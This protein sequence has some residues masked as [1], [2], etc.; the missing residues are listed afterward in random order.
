MNKFLVTE[1]VESIP[2]FLEY[3]EKNKDLVSDIANN[4]GH[5]ILKVFILNEDENKIGCIVEGDIKKAAAGMTNPEINSFMKEAGVK[6]DTIRT[7][8]YGAHAIRLKI[9]SEMESS[10]SKV[11]YNESNDNEE[12]ILIG[13][14]TGKLQPEICYK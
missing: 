12:V 6:L 11:L 5:K 7:D 1:E 14:E 2:K 3:Y 10:I 4:F 8:V 9:L 13:N